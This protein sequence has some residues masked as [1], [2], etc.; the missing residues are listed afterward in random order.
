MK[1]QAQKEKLEIFNLKNIESQ[2]KFKEY[3]SKENILSGIFDQDD[4]LDKLTETFIKKLK[5]CIA[6]NL[7]KIRINGHKKID[8]K[9]I[10]SYSKN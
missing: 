10:Q 9:E 5:G 8:E 1:D 6:Q 4:S 3:T 2:K 7:R